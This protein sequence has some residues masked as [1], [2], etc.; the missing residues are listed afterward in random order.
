ML[1]I[2]MLITLPGES[3]TALFTLLNSMSSACCSFGTVSLSPASVVT[4][5]LLF[6][7]PSDGTVCMETLCWIFIGKLLSQIITELFR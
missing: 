1:R 5:F 7:T 4:N 2:V 3:N 6:R